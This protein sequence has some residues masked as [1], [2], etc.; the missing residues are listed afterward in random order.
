MTLPSFFLARPSR[1]SFCRFIKRN[2]DL[3]TGLHV[4]DSD[5]ARVDLILTE[6]DNER[7]AELVGI[8]DLVA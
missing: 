1:M 4:L 3:L 8:A 7:D 5:N 2:L 6:E